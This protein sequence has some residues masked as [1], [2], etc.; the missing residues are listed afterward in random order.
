MDFK[1][2]IIFEP[3]L[4]ALRIVKR[5]S[6]QGKDDREVHKAVAHS[7][8]IEKQD[9]DE[10]FVANINGILVV[11]SRHMKQVRGGEKNARDA[12]FDNDYMAKVFKKLFLKP[13]FRPGKS[14]VA[15]RNKNGKYDLMAI[16][17]EP[18][19]R[20]IKIITFIKKNQ[21][22]AF[23]TYSTN[24][25]YKNDAKVMVEEFAE[26]G[27]DSIVAEELLSITEFY[28]VD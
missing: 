19:F 27:I 11:K 16:H 8:E 13:T 20:T 28:V 2:H 3:F 5:A 18:K 15:F 25:D 22:R 24:R 10:L 21:S 7:A 4:E 6:K 26:M 14:Q 1:A 17:Y 23:D 9:T 12:Y